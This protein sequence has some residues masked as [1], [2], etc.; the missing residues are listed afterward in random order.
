MTSPGLPAPTPI[1]AQSARR[2]LLL[3]SGTRWFPVGLTFGLAVLI[4][5]ERGI[6]LAQIGLILSAQ[7]FVMLALELPTGGLADALGRRPVLVLAGIIGLLSATTFLLADSVWVFV[8]ALAFQGVFRALDSGPL[9]SWYVDA[10]LAEDPG[11]EVEQSLSHTTTVLGVAIAAGAL[12]SGGLIAWDPLPSSAL[13][14]P[15]VVSIGIS[16]IHVVLVFVLVREPGRQSTDVAAAL[17]SIRTAPTIVVDGLRLLR[18]R[19]VL[20]G[21]VLVEVFWAVGMIG[22]ETLTPVRLA[23]LLGGE[24]RAGAIFGPSSAAAWGLFAVGSLLA[25]LLCR[26][27]GVARTAMI[28]RITNGSFILVMGLTAGPV[29]LISAYLLAYLTHGAGGPMHATLL[30]RQAEASNRATVLSMNSMVTGGAYSLGILA[31]GPLAASTSTATAIVVA[32]G[33]SIIGALF[34]LPAQREERRRARSPLWN[35]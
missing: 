22:F 20:R 11:V 13:I 14:L 24:A 26:R 15:Y 34:Y 3:L 18:R 28:S 7:G 9:E 30:H 12:V 2:R 23:E 5:L 19:T 6:G 33:F 21:L 17:T 35:D 27:I 32:G 29:G 16:A 1:S 31:L 10:A 25:G 8:L 4:P